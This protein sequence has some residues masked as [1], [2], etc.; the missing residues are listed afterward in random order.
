MVCPHLSFL[1]L[2]IVFLFTRINKNDPA[3]SCL[4]FVHTGR[5]HYTNLQYPDGFRLSCPTRPSIS[6]CGWFYPQNSRWQ[7]HRHIFWLSNHDIQWNTIR[8]NLKLHR[9]SRTMDARNWLLSTSGC[10]LSTF[11]LQKAPSYRRRSSG[12][13]YCLCHT[14]FPASTHTAFSQRLGTRQVLS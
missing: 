10:Y 7:W 2:N 11:I 14:A 13:L 5:S 3:C 12:S 6:R 4:I 9:S 8:K 1:S